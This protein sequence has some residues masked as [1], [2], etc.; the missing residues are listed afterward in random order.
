MVSYKLL[1]GIQA[2]LI[3][4]CGF[5]VLDFGVE[6]A[7]DPLGIE[8]EEGL[9]FNKI[10]FDQDELIK[11]TPLG[12]NDFWNVFTFWGYLMMLVAAIQVVKALT[13]SE[14]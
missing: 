12:A 8:D 11:D 14:F 5:S 3:L 13:V 2:I 1:A 6:M 7:R 9:G 4:I 10:L